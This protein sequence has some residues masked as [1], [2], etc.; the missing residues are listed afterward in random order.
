MVELNQSTLEFSF[1]DVHAQAMLEVH[2]QRTLRIPDDGKVYPLPPGLGAFP[3]RHV[4]DFARNVPPRWLE[5]GG[6]MFPMHQAEAMWICFSARYPFAVKVGTGLINAV[7][8]SPWRSGLHRRPQDYVVIPE[9]PWLDGFCVKKGQIRQFVAM[10]LGA[11]YSVEE[12]L[13]GEAKHGGLQLEVIPLRPEIFE[14]ELEAD[15]LG[16]P[17]AVLSP[18]ALCCDTAMGLAPGGKMLQQIFTDRRPI[19]DWNHEVSSRCF[20]HIANSLTW[21]HLTGEAPPVTPI[22]ARDY[23]QA[24]L[25][26]FDFY[27]EDEAA[28]EG[29]EAL[30]SAKSVLELGAERHESP[31]PE[32]ESVVPVNVVELRRGLRPNEVRVG[33]W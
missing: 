26:W 22:T 1:P 4:D 31:L 25:P 9:Q 13:T 29:G 21:K 30:R 23:E 18:S 11:G 14:K 24:G 16:Q 10:P 28:L 7:T 33:R 3:L 20:V 8:G 17:C 2:F 27:A 19:A 6:V 5:Q 32:N 12:Q 15:P